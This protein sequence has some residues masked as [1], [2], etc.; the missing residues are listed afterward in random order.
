[1]VIMKDI[2]ESSSSE[3]MEGISYGAAEKLAD[4]MIKNPRSVAM[5]DRYGVEA[6]EDITR[7]KDALVKFLI[8]YFKR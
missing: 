6:S 4:N 8:N 7:L 3:M 2:I 1:M 5:L